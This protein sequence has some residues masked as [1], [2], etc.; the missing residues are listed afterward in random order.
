L[1]IDYG[2]PGLGDWAMP[3]RL[4][5]LAPLSGIVFVVVALAA[6]FTSK[7]SP[8]AGASGQKVIAFYTAHSSSQKASDILFVIGFTFFLLFAG[9]LRS[10]LR[11]ESDGAATTALAGAALMTAGFG[12]LS[13]IDYAI[14]DHPGQ[15]TIATAQTLNTLD[16]DAFPVASA[17][18]LAFGLCGGFA[19]LNSSTLPRWLGYALVVLA[20]ASA[21]PAA[22]FGFFGI[23]IWTLVV[24]IMLY[25]RSGRATAPRSAP[26]PAAV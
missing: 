18:A 2:F 5:R 24:S 17:G 21:T 1:R 25:V 7:T 23:I 15:L 26:I 22:I 10:A 6:I 8:S 14:A 20:I 16:N 3:E 4:N 9:A 12:V 19:I 11:G 13:V